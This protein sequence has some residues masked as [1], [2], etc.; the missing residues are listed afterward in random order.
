MASA[1]ALDLPAQQPPVIEGVRRLAVLRANG[2]GDYVVA[3][4]ALA[5]LRAAYPDAEITLLGAAHTRPLVQDRPGPCD[6]F[7]EVPLTTGVRVGPDP[8]AA[9]EVMAAW[10]AA[11]RAYGYDL[12]LQ[13]HGGGRN[14]NALLLRLGAATTA[15]AATPNA[16]NP[17]AGCPTHPSSTT[18]CAGWRW[19]VRSGRARGGSSPTWR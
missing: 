18:R 16:P 7:V 4:P 3:E 13:L 2:I 11:Q 12:A 15:G 10:C 1:P 17:T 5:A 19:S 9:P 6:R 14:S 8:D